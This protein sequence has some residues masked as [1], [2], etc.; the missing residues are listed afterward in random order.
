LNVEARENTHRWPHVLPRGAGVL[1]NASIAY[2]NYDEASIAVASLKDHQ[3]KTLLAHAGMS[4]RYLPSGHL[5]YVTKGGLFAVPFDVDRLEI[6]GPAVRLES[7]SSNPN[8]GSAQMDFSRN[9]TFVYRTGGTEGLRTLQWVD[10]EGRTESLGFEPAL[11]LFT[12]LS[13]DGNR[14]AYTVSQGPTT[15]LYIYDLQRGIKAR[16]TNG[17]NALNVVWSRDGE[18]V[19]FQTPSGMFWKRADGAGE[20]RL[21]KRR[22]L[23]FPSSFSREGTQFAFTQ[24]IL[25][26]G[27]EIWTLPVNVTRGQLQAGE[28]RLL[29]KT[30]SPLTF[31]ALSPD[32]RWLAY[33]DAEGGTYQIYVRAFPDR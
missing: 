5:V 33:A 19:I 21:L 7:V 3:T 23:V 12:R 11:Y 20:A 32:G 30:A 4:P 1:F 29:L 17:E 27:G 24:Q 14:L 16:L 9:G 28:P 22:K 26:G 13:P 15:D 8:L 31:P 18:F 6:T 2:G 10:S 25:A